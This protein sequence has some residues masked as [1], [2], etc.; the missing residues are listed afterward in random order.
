MGFHHQ[1]NEFFLSRS[2]NVDTLKICD[3][4]SHTEHPEC[5]RFNVLPKRA[6]GHYEYFGQL[7]TDC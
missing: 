7:N 2:N 4:S 6:E 3:A 1:H 5:A